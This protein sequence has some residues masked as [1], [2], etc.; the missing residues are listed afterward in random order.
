MAVGKGFQLTGN[1]VVI[2]A[3]ITDRRKS[4]HPLLATSSWS[5][6]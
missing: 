5:T 3:P 6:V 1:E 2:E 4:E